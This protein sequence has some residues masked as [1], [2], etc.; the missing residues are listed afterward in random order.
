MEFFGIAPLLPFS[1]LSFLPML[2]IA[3]SR[4]SVVVVV[5]ADRSHLFRTP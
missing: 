4:V 3:G 2:V 5:E 1:P